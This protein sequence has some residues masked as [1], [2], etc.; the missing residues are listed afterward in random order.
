[1]PVRSPGFELS[2]LR[3]LPLIVLLFVDAAGARAAQP[4]EYE[5]KAAFLLNFAKFVEW[6]ADAFS[7]PGDPV[8]LCVLGRDPFGEV[9]DET[10]RDEQVS[11]R[12]LMVRRLESDAA[13]AGCHIL[14]VSAH[15]RARFASILKNV[16]TR[17]T[18][19]VSDRV[20][21]LDAG[22]HLAFFLEGS[23]VRFA[24]NSDA[25]ARFD[26]Q[27]SSR[28]MQVAR[29]HKPARGAVLSQPHRGATHVP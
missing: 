3:Y 11:N 19:T 12:P 9:L 16:N 14:F 10:V 1:M 18:L 15:E 5:V 21:F 23:R 20:D 8:T 13:S 4:L 24:A 22:G 2:V 26:Y 7:G 6:G 27:V 25:V 29:I 28:V 17:R